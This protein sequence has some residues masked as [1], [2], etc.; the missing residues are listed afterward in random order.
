MREPVLGDERQITRGVLRG[1]SHERYHGG[2]GPGNEEA[3]VLRQRGTG[4][5]LQGGRARWSR[6]GGVAPR[7]VAWSRNTNRRGRRRGDGHSRR[8]RHLVDGRRRAGHL[9]RRRAVAQ[10]DLLLPERRCRRHGAARAAAFSVRC[11]SE[12]CLCPTTF[13]AASTAATSVVHG[14]GLKQARTSRDGGRPYIGGCDGHVGQPGWNGDSVRPETQ[15]HCVF[16]FI[17]SP[18]YSLFIFLSFLQNTIYLQCEFS[19]QCIFEKS[20]SNLNA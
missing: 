6:P 8:R 7:H 5:R 3:L 13:T 16:G 11:D 14:G 4:R 19:K 20:F 9:L 17:N 15:K 18:K 1:N 12:V 2:P 10:H